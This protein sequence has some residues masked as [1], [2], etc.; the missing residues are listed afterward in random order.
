MKRLRTTFPAAV[1]ALILAAALPLS[2]TASATD[3]PTTAPVAGAGGCI[4]AGATVDQVVGCVQGVYDQSQTFISHFQQHFWVKAYNQEKTSSGHVTFVKPGKMSWTY[5]DD[6]S[7]GNRVVSDGTTVKVYEASNKQMYEQTLDKSQYPA[8]LSFL[9]G[10]GKLTDSFTFELFPGEQMKYPGGLVL[11]GTPK[12]ATPA[13]SKVLFYVDQ[14]TAQ[15]QR[16]LIIDLQGNRN[17]FD[18]DE[19]K[20]NTQVPPETFKYT[21]PPG[22]SVIHP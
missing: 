5:E 13:Y 17:R 18:F 20:V 1:A 7:K 3:T 8:A 21:P 16:A 22:T 10:T 2:A 15:I 14:G 9:T 6:Q 19:A 11:V 4:V 12:Q